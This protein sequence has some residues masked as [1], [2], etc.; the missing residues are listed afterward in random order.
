[1][2]DHKMKNDY[3][4]NLTSYLHPYC[5]E[6][7]KPAK[8]KERKEMRTNKIAEKILKAEFLSEKK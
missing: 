5:R 7:V 6:Q 3:N 1:M 8:M 2:L 4:L